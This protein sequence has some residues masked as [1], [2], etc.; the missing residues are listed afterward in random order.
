MSAKEFEPDGSSRTHVFDIRI[1]ATTPDVDD[2]T[3]NRDDFASQWQLMRRRF[4]KH[5]LAIIGMAVL[6]FL[7]VGAILA[8]FLSPHNPI[9]RSLPY[10]EAPPQRVR[11]FESNR[12]RF[13]FVYPLVGERNRETYKTVY[14]EDRSQRYPIQL[15]VRGFTYKLFGLFETDRHLFG[16][17]VEAVP[18]HLFG[19]DTFG[20]DIL[21]RTLFGSQISLSIGLVGVVISFVLGILI[22]G[23]AGYF[24]GRLDDI[25]SRGIDILISIPQLPLWMG[26]GAALPLGWPVVKTYFAITIILSLL[27]WT[28]LARVV[29]GKFMSLRE[30][31]FVVAA[32]LAGRR[33]ISIIFVHMV[34]S[35]LSHIIASLTLTIPGMILAETSLSFLGLG[36]QAPA[37]SWG[38]LLKAAQNVYTMALAPWNMIPG[39]F[40]I[41]TVLAFSFVGDGLRDAAD[42]YS[43]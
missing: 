23:L 1:A 27:G 7:Y 26:L 4:F 17:G 13:P 39:L 28:T 5:K 14:T 9:Q 21:S 32:R 31:D 43:A 11:I 8:P 22:G 15:F 18:V 33:D 35:F 16:T 10:R 30:E 12:I 6:T 42:P 25:I 38:V 24:G 40:V 41:V 2:T 29:R 3:V 20:R 19:T 34:P 37:I 36:M